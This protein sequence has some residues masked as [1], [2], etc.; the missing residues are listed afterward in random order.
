MKLSVNLKAKQFQISRISWAHHSDLG[1]LAY[2]RQS[3]DNFTD[4][5]TI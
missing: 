4:R 1:V 3:S 2:F 5:S